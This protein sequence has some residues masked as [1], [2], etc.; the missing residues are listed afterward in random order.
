MKLQLILVYSLFYVTSLFGVTLQSVY[1]NAGPANG[2][3][4]YLVLNSEVIYTGEIGIFEGNVFIEGNGS[5]V[6]LASGLGIW[7]Y[8]DLNYP[9][10]LNIEYLTIVNGGY[11]AITYNGKSTGNITNCNFINNEFGIQVMDEAEINI[12]NSNFIDNLEYGIAVRGTLA[13]IDI[14]H[15]NFWENGLGCAGYNQNC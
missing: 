12:K 13:S 10:S 1:N 4:K 9:A 15:S 3:D 14:T 6:D 11:N 8:A 7:I 5:I 2:Y